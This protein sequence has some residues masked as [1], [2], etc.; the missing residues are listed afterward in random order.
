[1]K[2]LKLLLI[3]ILSLSVTK[4]GTDLL[5]SQKSN[6]KISG[7]WK[8]SEGKYLSGIE[9]A[10][11]IQYLQFNKDG[12]GNLILKNPS[13]GILACTDV[14]FAV[15]TDSTFQIS[16]NGD[17]GSVSYIYEKPDGSNLTIKDQ[18]SNSLNFEFNDEI[19]QNSQCMDFTVEN[20]YRDFTVEPDN[21]SD[22]VWDGTYLWF[23]DEEDSGQIY[24]FDPSVGS[25]GAPFDLGNTGC[26]AYTFIQSYQRGYYWAHCNCG[27]G[28]EIS[29]RNAAGL[30][31]DVVDTS[32]YGIGNKIEIDVATWDGSNL[33]L[34]GLNRFTGKDRMLKVDS[35]SLSNP[36]LASYEFDSNIRGLSNDGT[37]LWA[38]ARWAPHQTIA[39][40]DTDHSNFTAVATY[41][42][43]DLDINWIGVEVVNSS[44]YLL[45]VDEKNDNN[46]VIFKVSP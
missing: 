35:N 3:L 26:N 16:L 20:E 6:S 38:I 22:L 15:L 27:S 19:P 24:P 25:L 2:Y 40:I 34:H 37:Y 7:I 11:W 44:L 21:N 36:L 5:N 32:G 10:A 29:K 42:S 23:T 43:P 14:I 1:M 46:A 8:L 17:F 45:G 9:N 18:N 4:C 33:W 31:F 13:T 28:N 30:E 12:T 39:K 41:N